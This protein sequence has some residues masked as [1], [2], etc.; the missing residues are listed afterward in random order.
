MN[1]L[2]ATIFSKIVG[3][4][5]ILSKQATSNSYLKNLI[6]FS[7]RKNFVIFNSSGSWTVPVGVSV[8]DVYMESSGGKGNSGSNSF[9]GGS[10]AFVFLKNYINIVAG[11][12]IYLSV[13]TTSGTH[14]TVLTGDD[15]TTVTCPGGTD[16]T[17][18]SRGTNTLETCHAAF[19]NASS[20]AGI[21]SLKSGG[22]GLDDGDPVE[23]TGGNGIVIIFY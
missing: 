1:G 6:D 11:N 8:I 7:T 17:T 15:D 10:G 23:A 18:G 16:A 4:N 3:N 21:V 20:G 9:Q 19:S 13:G 12:T 14:D 2:L 5:G 22:I